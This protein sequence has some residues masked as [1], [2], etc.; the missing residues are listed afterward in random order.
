MEHRPTR[1]S[2]LPRFPTILDH[3]E[4]AMSDWSDAENHV[5]RAHEHYEAG[6]WDDAE[7]E[8]REALALNPYRSEWHF[9]LG[10]T[11][12]AAGRFEAAARAFHDAADLD[13][14]DSHVL[15][16]LGVSWLR[17]DRPDLALPHLERAH[18]LDTAAIEPIVHLIEAYAR[19]DR[20][21]DA[22]V[23]FYLALQCQGDHAP[24]YANMAEGLFDRDEF[25]RALDCWRQAA[26]LDPA[27]PRVHA[28]LA[29]AHERLGHT[30]QARA[31][32]L[33][34]LRDNPGDV[35]TLLDLAH[36]LIEVNRLA[37]A[38]EKLTRILEIAP[39]T[40]E[41]HFYLG[42]IALRRHRPHTAA[43]HFTRA[44][45]L[46]PRCAF[47][48]AR[49]AAIDLGRGA[50]ADARRRLRRELRD[51][52]ADPTARDAEELAE[53]G[54]LLIDARLPREAITVLRESLDR[55]PDN[56]LSW[57]HLGVALFQRDDAAGGIAATRRA[58]RA[59]PRL[60]PAL[61]NLAL[62][63]SLTGNDARARAILRH[64]LRVEPDDPL[65]RR[66]WLTI[67]WRR[68]IRV[69][70]WLARPVTRTA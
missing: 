18:R 34:E 22:E 31:L 3:T 29:M 23:M 55:D 53:L 32:Y 43:D 9:N 51:H 66:L 49:L 36:L 14:A 6:R 10:L 13:P 42:E 46:D 27:L 69:V 60:V 41:A 64:A 45:D 21:D 28:R 67:R 37:E 68:I 33:R 38:D 40:P 52:R 12:E 50:V 17:A 20:H 57:H 24:A 39:Q 25:A 63:L 56:A 47:A 70:R 62:A 5:E 65:L 19:T 26:A 2:A 30:E 54:S 8:L 4:H 7:T 59:D 15:I 48:R 11:L 61:H 1:F 16:C 35:D 44:L 58:V